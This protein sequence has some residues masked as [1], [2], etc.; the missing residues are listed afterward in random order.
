M[1]K[2]TN[3]PRKPTPKNVPNEKRGHKGRA[4]FLQFTNYATSTPKK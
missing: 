3:L 1:N 2:P 4:L